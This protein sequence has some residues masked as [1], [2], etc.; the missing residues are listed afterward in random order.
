[1]CE[2]I[3]WL[4]FSRQSGC[5]EKSFQC[6]IY[7]MHLSN[8]F[9]SLF[10][11]WWLSPWKNWHSRSAPVLNPKPL[12]SFGTRNPKSYN[13]EIIIVISHNSQMPFSSPLF[14]TIITLVNYFQNCLFVSIALFTCVDWQQFNT[15]KFMLC[16]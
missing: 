11:V 8:Y 6:R 5:E 1:M 14:Q 15:S 7:A 3:P 12:S 4:F 13:L 2:M 10:F 9:S 16:M